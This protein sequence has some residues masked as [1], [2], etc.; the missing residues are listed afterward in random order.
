MVTGSKTEYQT[1]NLLYPFSSVGRPRGVFS[2]LTFLGSDYLQMLQS[3]VN[4][5]HSVSR[6]EYPRP[7]ASTAVSNILNLAMQRSFPS[8]RSNSHLMN[9][10]GSN[11]EVDV[12]PE[13]NISLGVH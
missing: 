4:E 6:G 1:S 9:K 3:L 2:L 7:P 12:T 13:E 5:C 11:E 8:G 10:I